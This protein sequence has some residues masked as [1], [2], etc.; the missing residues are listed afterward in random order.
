MNSIRSPLWWACLFAT[1]LAAP[2]ALGR[3][4]STANVPI[5]Q[6][7]LW[8][9]RNGQAQVHF[10]VPVAVP[11]AEP[12]VRALNA[13]LGQQ[14]RGPIIQSSPSVWFLRA[15]GV[16]VFRRR[17]L[18]VEGEVNLAP[19]LEELRPLG[20]DF[21]EV[22]IHHPPAGFTEG[23]EAMSLSGGWS[24]TEYEFIA[25]V[26]AEAPPPLRLAYGYDAADWWRLAPLAALLLLPVGLT[27]AVRRAALRAREADPFVVCYRFWQFQQRQGI[28]LVCLWLATGAVLDAS[29]FAAFVL[30][31][32]VTHPYLI[33]MPAFAA[34]PILVLIGCRALAQ[35]LWA[36][37]PEVDWS[38]GQ[39]ARRAFWGTTAILAFFL[40]AGAAAYVAGEV[41]R[42]PALAL[43]V[44][45]YVCCEQFLKYW[46]AAQNVRQE[47]LPAGEVRDR[48]FMLARKAAVRVNQVFLLP[49]ARWR[50]LP[51]FAPLPHS[52]YL[53]KPLFHHLSRREMDALLAHALA[54]LWRRHV[55]AVWRPFLQMFLIVLFLGSFVGLRVL[56]STI[57]WE[58]WLLL[59]PIPWLLLSRVL[60]GR[61]LPLDSAVDSDAVALTGDPE[62]LITALAKLSRLGLLPV[63]SSFWSRPFFSEPFPWRR[64]EALAAREGIPPERLDEI[65]D[66]PGTGSEQYPPLPDGDRESKA[67]VPA[68]PGGAGEKVFATY[69]SRVGAR[70]LRTLVAVG[71]LTPALV[72]SLAESG[73]WDSPVR[74]A[75]YL[76][77]L[78]V[79]PLLGL[80]ALE[81]VTRWGIGGLER[82]L[83][84]KMEGQGIAVGDWGG[85]LVGLAPAGGPR[86][87]EN[88]YDWDMGFLFLAGDRLC[89]VG[90]QTCFAL[91]RDQVTEVLLGL[92]PP[93]W[94]AS[95]RLY[96][97][98][99]DGPDG[100]GGTFSLRVA[101]RYSLGAGR[102][103]T[104]L[105]AEK[106]RA[107][108]KG[109][110]TATL[111]APL[112]VLAAPSFGGVVGESP[113]SARR[114]NKALLFIMLVPAALVCMILRLPF[115]PPDGVAG[116]YVLLVAAA[117]VVL[118]LL[119]SWRY[120]DPT[121]GADEA[122]TEEDR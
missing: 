11:D 71:V 13:A 72:A 23:S 62:A 95:Q 92:G 74:P 56:S 25:F 69:R 26:D 17:G 47:P 118:L 85:I 48:L 86:L 57:D 58:R 9:D 10:Y 103:Q 78:I 37:V 73:P 70:I 6:L 24:D 52:I 75:L 49:P 22:S 30:S 98:W 108:W 90:E 31:A 84:A 111:P 4:E 51:L 66:G 32:W 53:T 44:V 41:G 16:E 105:F 33:I 121:D 77:G 40:F 21:L 14:L 42:P 5:A 94:L 29:K 12:L 67:A 18:M 68:L 83:R 2:P 106:V 38:A 93:G 81:G 39:A 109:T 28:L 116:W 46:M 110:E 114:G 97:T 88:S 76:G 89:Y 19:L 120:R 115:Q 8:A 112:A 61:L 50:L 34:P 91:R 96:I 64:L 43:I 101:E 7:T 122:E 27:L 45:G 113:R 36:R 55:R 107:W 87:Y 3:L 82:Q 100:T 79:T 65:L 102:R 119:P 60:G 63:T 117:V 80:L 1:T 104:T 35:P 59:L 15:D 99:Q 20:V 54:Y